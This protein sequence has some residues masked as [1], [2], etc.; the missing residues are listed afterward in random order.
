MIRRTSS[1]TDVFIRDGMVEGAEVVEVEDEEAAGIGL[2]SGA[3]MA[4]SRAFSS[5][6]CIL[7]HSFRVWGLGRAGASDPEE[8]RR[9]SFLGRVSDSVGNGFK[10]ERR[11]S[12]GGLAAEELAST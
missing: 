11:L 5:W 9:V 6:R 10:E 12:A 8:R 1:D 4:A 7:R 2:G 3:R